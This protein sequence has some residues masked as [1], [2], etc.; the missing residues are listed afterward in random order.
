MRRRTHP[1]RHSRNTPTVIPATHPRHS[2]VGGNLDAPST[3][4]SPSASSDIAG[5]GGIPMNTS[6]DA[7]RWDSRLRGNDV[8]ISHEYVIGHRP[9]DSRLRGNDVMREAGMTGVFPM[10]TSS[11]ADR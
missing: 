2:R 3:N 8:G 7:D 5:A 6:S 9:L 10:S 1:S 4:H 11:D